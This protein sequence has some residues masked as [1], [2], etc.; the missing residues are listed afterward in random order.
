MFKTLVC[1]SILSNLRGLKSSNS[2]VHLYE[3]IQINRYFQS[4]IFKVSSFERSA[5]VKYFRK[6]YNCTSENIQSVMYNRVR[7]LVIFW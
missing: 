5:L 4:L 1:L 6:K 3:D 2:T 7:L